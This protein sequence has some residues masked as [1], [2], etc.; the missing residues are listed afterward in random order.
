MAVKIFD[1]DGSTSTISIIRGIK[2]AT[3]NGAKVINASFG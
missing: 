3:N 2:F 1:Q